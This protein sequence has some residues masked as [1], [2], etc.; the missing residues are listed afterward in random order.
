MPPAFCFRYE[1]EEPL[2]SCAGHALAAVRQLP[3]SR[4]VALTHPV[5]FPGYRIGN[6]WWSGG[7]LTPT[8]G[9]YDKSDSSL[10]YPYHEYYYAL[11]ARAMLWACRRE[12]SLAIAE[13][14]QTEQSLQV[15]LQGQMG[16]YQGLRLE[17]ELLDDSFAVLG[18]ADSAISQASMTAAISLPQFFGTALLHLQ[19]KKETAV[20]D[21]AAVRLNRPSPL[22]LLAVN[23]AI[24]AEGKTAELTGTL[25][26]NGGGK[27]ELRLPDSWQRLVVRQ[28]MALTEGAIISG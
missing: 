21:F 20:L 3:Q 5:G 16:D 13:I 15:A 28:E 11:L 6:P 10:S 27:A 18:Q 4:V 1:A 22:R 12:S 25:Q 24:A 8:A 7:G 19:L 23:T 9:T 14:R 26:V 17:W 2:L